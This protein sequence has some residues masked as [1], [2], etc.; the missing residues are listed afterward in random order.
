MEIVQA[1]KAEV[2][3]KGKD[4]RKK[5]S[6]GDVQMGATDGDEKVIEGEVWEVEL[7]D[8]V[9]FP[10]GRSLSYFLSPLTQ[11]TRYSIRHNIVTDPHDSLA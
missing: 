10:E 7:K 11:R 2:G 6:K 8:T 5:K 9:L 1:K 4:E 3:K